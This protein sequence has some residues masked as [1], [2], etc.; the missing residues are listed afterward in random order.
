MTDRTRPRVDDRTGADDR[1]RR[2]RIHAA[3]PD[4][5]TGPASAAGP[6]VRPPGEAAP[7]GAPSAGLAPARRA[8]GLLLAMLTALAALTTAVTPPPAQAARAVATHAGRYETVHDQVWNGSY[9]LDDGR[10]VWCAFDPHHPGPLTGDA[11]YSEWSATETFL[12]GNGVMMDQ[13]VTARAAYVLARWGDTTDEREA[14]AV[15][16]VLHEHTGVGFWVPQ[17]RDLTADVADLADWMWAQAD[18]GL[19]PHRLDDPDLRVHDDGQRA[20]VRLSLPRSAADEPHPGT[21][22]ATI[23]GPAVWETTG[24]DRLDI[25]ADGEHRLRATGDGQ[26]TV[27]VSGEVPT[28]RLLVASPVTPGPQRVVSAGERTPITA[29]ATATVRTTF[30]PVATTR[31]TTWN[32]ATSPAGAG[33]APGDRLEDTLDVRADDGVWLADPDTDEPVPATF[34]VDWYR[35]DRAMPAS[36]SVPDGVEH[37]ARTL[38]TAPGPGTI[39]ATS[40]DPVD[41]PGW[42][43]PVVSLLRED[44]PDQLRARFRADWVSGFHDTDEQTI[45]PWRPAV[46]TVTSAIADGMIAD[47][48]TVTGNDPTATL[49]VVSEL[50]MADDAPT[51]SGTAGPPTDAERLAAVTTAVTGNTTVTTEPVAIPWTRFLERQT[52]PSLYWVER[53]ERTASTETWTGRH[54]I[55]AETVRPQRPTATTTTADRVA[56]GQPV[57]DRAVV[58]GDVPSGGAEAVTAE[59]GF[60]LYR[61]DDS[62]DGEAQPVCETPTWRQEPAVT[63]DS[64]GTV[65]SAA[66]TP[67]VA[68]TYGW[69]HHLQVR[70]PATAEAPER[71]IPLEDG[72]CGVENETVVVTAHPTPVTETEPEPTGLAATGLPAGAAALVAGAATL[73]VGG[74]V[75]GA[76]AARRGRRGAR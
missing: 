58:T 70:V 19:G 26:V 17:G 37:V 71:V 20:T 54:L 65:D 3:A 53:I 25:D 67:T 49:S 66:T 43:Y 4:R 47:T 11:E 5:P 21:V 48:I 68:G 7:S 50:W 59:L 34:R 10:I 30:Q 23:D 45:A 18:R 16:R 39:T 51:E 8:L 1:A 76:I 74:G 41:R 9:R 40:P 36:A 14:R 32:P 69:R 57:H 33:P 12:S 62:T 31:A 64:P 60:S 13:A 75:T 2:D 61:F 35:A 6:G 22:T 24:T 73:L 28:G 29:R 63:I 52:W 46:S 56:L 44:Q 55:A 27:A 42:Y 15:Y 72:A 38:V